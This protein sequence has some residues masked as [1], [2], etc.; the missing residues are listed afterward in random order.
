MSPELG[1]LPRLRG[2]VSPFYLTQT[3]NRTHR[4]MLIES[5]LT[6]ART[7]ANIEGGSKKRIF[8][9]LANTFAENLCDFDSNEIYQSLIAREKLGSTGLGQGIAIPHCRFNTSGETYGVCLTLSTP[10]D[11]DAADNQ[12]VDIIFAMLVP[13]DA[14]SSHLE[15]LSALAET[16]QNNYFVA[17]IRS[18]QSNEAVF[19]AVTQK[20]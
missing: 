7:K 15:A 6:P 11:F 12:P 8:E 2:I 3:L 4:F 20:A 9:T 10:I 14:Q 17:K 5:I 19:N 16:M 13:E 1:F 18:A